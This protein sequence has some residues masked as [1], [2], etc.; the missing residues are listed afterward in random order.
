[1]KFWL[2][3]LLFPAFSFAVAAVIMAGGGEMRYF[4]GGIVVGNTLA[5]IIDML[6][7]VERYLSGGE[8]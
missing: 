5:H 8:G 4:L 7:L 1:M 2:A 6:N 3:Y